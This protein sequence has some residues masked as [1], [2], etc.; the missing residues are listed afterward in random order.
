MT[1]T[2]FSAKAGKI[3]LAQQ[4]QVYNRQ[5]IQCIFRASK[6]ARAI[7]NDFPYEFEFTEITN[8]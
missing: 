2:S 3:Q 6:I 5:Y 4:C 7:Y 1:N 8:L